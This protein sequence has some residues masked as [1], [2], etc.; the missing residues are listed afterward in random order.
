MIY[1]YQLL[2]IS[3]N[4][5][6]N[7]IWERIMIKASLMQLTGEKTRGTLPPPSLGHDGTPDKRVNTN[8]RN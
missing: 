5:L 3:I 6:I 1:V 8:W 4:Q 2:N 7:I